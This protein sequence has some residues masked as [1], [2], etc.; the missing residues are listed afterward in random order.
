MNC[1]PG[2]LA[3]IVMCPRGTEHLRGRVLRLTAPMA[4]PQAPGV[5]VD[6]T[7]AWGYEG[8]LMHAA[9]GLAIRWVN[10]CCVRPIRDNGG[11]DETLAWASKPN[12]VMA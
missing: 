10:D 1:K 7:V 4:M 11:D 12:E 9:C 3:V 8:P 5:S 6:T 2:D